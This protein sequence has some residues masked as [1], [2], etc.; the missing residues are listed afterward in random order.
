VAAW[1]WLCTY[2]VAARVV[3]NWFPLSTFDMYQG[4]APEVVARVM[5]VDAEGRARELG[6]Y[7]GY[8]CEPA[9][10]ELAAAVAERCSE[11]HRPLPYVVRDQQLWL[12]AHVEA[13]GGPEAIAIVARAYALAERPGAPAF[14]DCELARCTARRRGGSP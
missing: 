14:T 9:A 11:E 5:A 3:G 8:A 1:A 2:V 4:H 12:E 7:E 13:A 10:V 6:H